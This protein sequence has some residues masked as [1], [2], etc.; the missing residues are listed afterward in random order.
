MPIPVPTTKDERIPTSVHPAD[1]KKRRV[2]LPVRRVREGQNRQRLSPALPETV[3]T[4]VLPA[5]KAHPSAVR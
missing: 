5:E 2:L 4:V 3:L 1:S